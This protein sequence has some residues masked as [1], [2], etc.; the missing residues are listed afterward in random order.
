MVLDRIA[1]RL[2]WNATVRPRQRRGEAR[3]R[4]RVALKAVISPTTSVAIVNI[5]GDGSATLYCGTV[6]MGQGSDTAMA[7][8]V[9]EV[10]NMPASRCGWYRAIPTSRPTTWARSAPVRCSIWATPC[11]SPPKR[12]ATRS[13]AL[14]RELGEP[15][16][17]N[18]P[19]GDL[20]RKKVRHAGRQYCRHRHLQARLH[21]ARC[22]TGKRPTRRRSGWWPAPASRSR[23]TP[24]RDMCGSRG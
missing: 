8:M 17:S 22:R 13:R 14:R 4:P 11:G 3:P 10:L 20:F 16:G 21:P 19:L 2:N 7:Q 5:A 18:A 15:A 23:S 1:E 24:R 12:R 6:D 9:G